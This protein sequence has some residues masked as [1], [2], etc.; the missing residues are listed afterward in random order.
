MKVILFF[1]AMIICGFSY[2]GDYT[3]TCTDGNKTLKM[4]QSGE[5][6]LYIQGYSPE[7]ATSPDDGFVRT[8]NTVI[9]NTKDYYGKDTDVTSQIEVSYQYNGFEAIVITPVFGDEPGEPVLQIYKDSKLIK[10]LE[11]TYNE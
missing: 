10:D 5:V 8:K 9:Y 1:V 11:C 6:Y 2:A 4:E 3:S 7:N